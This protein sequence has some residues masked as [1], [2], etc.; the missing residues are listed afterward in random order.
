MM[1]GLSSGSVF[2]I[3]FAQF[4]GPESRPRSGSQ[5]YTNSL[6][7]RIWFRNTDTV[8]LYL[9]FIVIFQADIEEIMTNREEEIKETIIS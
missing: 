6:L 8:L 1:F 9:I 3:I 7:I 2:P 4:T 5:K